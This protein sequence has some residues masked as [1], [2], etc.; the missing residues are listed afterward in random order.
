M[1]GLDQFINQDDRK[2]KLS[3][4]FSRGV[5]MVYADA[6]DL[7]M[8]DTALLDQLIE[9]QELPG[10]ITAKFLEE[11]KS[12]GASPSPDPSPSPP[13]SEEKI[14][15]T[16]VVW[17]YLPNPGV[18]KT[19]FLTIFTSRYRK[20]SRML[21]KRPQL[22]NA[23]SISNV[24]R[25]KDK[26]EVSVI[27]IISDVATLK[28]GRKIL[29]V[30]DPTGSIKVLVKNNMRGVEELVPDEVI[31]IR[32]APGR[33]IIF[34]NTLVFPDISSS[35]SWPTTGSSKVIFLADIHA[36]SKKF[37]EETWEK[38]T[39]WV[40]QN[41]DVKH[42]FIGGDLVDGV[43]IYKGQDAEIHFETAEEEFVYLR[44]LLDMISPKKQLI[45]IPGNHD[46]TNDSEPRQPIPREFAKPIYQMNNL[47]L[48]SDP[49]WVNV[50]GVCVLMYHGTSFD[51]FIDSVDSIR[52]TA[53]DNPTQAQQLL[54]RKRHL[55][56]IFGR[57]RILPGR[58]DHLV[59]HQT[60]HVFFTGH[61]HTVDMSN[62][63][64]VRLVSAG[65]FQE[66]TDFQKKLGHHP[67]PGKFVEMD[68]S[69]GQ[70]RIIDFSGDE[71]PELKP[72]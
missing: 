40:N 6:L 29:E 25:I 71:L 48:L 62:Y 52:N 2:N 41:Q 20:L 45:V 19:D 34:A 59:I 11:L 22:R 72:N 47:Q 54:L 27:G 63:R 55:S 3:S 44:R 13:G 16:E 50:E 12:Q 53:Y 64:G 28:D 69:T 38:F 14:T 26:R 67:T 31:G 23:T 24:G 70:G 42:V 30:E 58:E 32:G 37:N 1:A 36:G 35:N 56:P 21:W 9:T 60:P 57:N 10:E 65:S 43:G 15:G 49:S 8:K 66:R 18:G 46:P 61:V 5:R 39:R 7:L 51:G 17:K 68:L 33:D 4:L